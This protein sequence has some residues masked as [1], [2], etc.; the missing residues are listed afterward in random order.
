ML[1][2][3]NNS[4][5]QW[6]QNV[7]ERNKTHCSLYH[8]QYFCPCFTHRYRLPSASW[9]CS[10]YIHKFSYTYPSPITLNNNCT[11][12]GNHDVCGSVLMSCMCLGSSQVDLPLTSSILYCFCVPRMYHT[13][14]GSIC[15]FMVA[16][17]CLTVMEMHFAFLAGGYFATPLLYLLPPGMRRRECSYL[18]T[19]SQSLLHFLCN[20]N[21]LFSWL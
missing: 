19:A 2:D 3:S 4:V 17:C 18:S 7:H 9:T 13:F 1:V 5:N 11:L 15:L 10:L 6:Y 21:C 12:P 20:I 16:L 8:G 14:S